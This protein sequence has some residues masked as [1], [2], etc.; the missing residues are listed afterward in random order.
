M[1]KLSTKA[2]NL[3]SML[4]EKIKGGTPLSPDERTMRNWF[5]RQQRRVDRLN[6]YFAR[7]MAY[8]YSSKRQDERQRRNYARA[9]AKRQERGYHP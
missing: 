4:A 9:M 3:L 2:L 5:E 1:F 6:R 7:N 8:P